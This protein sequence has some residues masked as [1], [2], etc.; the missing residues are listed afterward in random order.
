MPITGPLVMPLGGGGVDRPAPGARFDRVPTGNG[1]D[2]I[3][4]DIS[5]IPDLDPSFTLRSGKEVLGEALVRRLTTARGSLAYAP[6][7]GIDIRDYLNRAF[8]NRLLARLRSYMEAE[9]RRDE[10]VAEVSVTLSYTAATQTIAAS[11]EV[12]SAEGPFRLTLGVSQ[13]SV[14]LLTVT[15]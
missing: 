5:A 13:T 4:T 3:G 14:E 11:I 15:P 7:Y 12:V 8:D 2:A 9:L 6:N 10:R 1:P